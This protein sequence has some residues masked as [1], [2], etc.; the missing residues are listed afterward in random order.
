M[1]KMVSSLML[2]IPYSN[3]YYK[4]LSVIN[5]SFNSCRSISNSLRNNQIK[6]EDAALY[7]FDRKTK[8]L[9][10]ERAAIAKDVSVYDY[11]KDEVGYRL[12]DRIY[13]IKRRFKLAAD[14]GKSIFS[15]S[16]SVDKVIEF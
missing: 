15:T 10:R 6:N 16:R 1:V 7:I 5:S 4:Y 12:A 3:G 13:D 11:V 2:R 14:I 8:F 9:Q